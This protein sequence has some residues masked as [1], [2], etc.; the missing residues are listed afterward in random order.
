MDALNRFDEAGSI[1]RLMA[2]LT[3]GSS[4]VPM[5]RNFYAAATYMALGLLS[6]LF[7]REFTKATDFPAG[8]YSQLNTLHTHILVLGMIVFLVVLALDAL[9][10]LSGR[11]SFTVFFWL[12][13]AGLLVTLA[14]MVTRGILT[15]NGLT[16]AET[17]AAIPGIAGL[18]HIMITGGLIA[19][20]VALGSAVKERQAQ[21]SAEP[22]SVLSPQRGSSVT[23]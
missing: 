4:V 15:V 11:K 2:G 22:A 19:L 3:C 8:E 23:S 9:F 13:N 6:G 12:Y 21:L 5:T 20:F 14:M 1:F 16:E 17:T 10:A 18:G 7:Y